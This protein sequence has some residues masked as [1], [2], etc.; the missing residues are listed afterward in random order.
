MK[1][2]PCAIR[3]QSEVVLVQSPGMAQWL[4]MSLAEQFGIAANIAFPLPAT[5][6][7]DMFVRVLPEI[8]K[9]SAFNK[10]SMSWKLMAILPAM[11]PGDEFDTAAHYLSDDDDQ[12]K[13]FQLSRAWRI[14]LTSIWFIARNGSTAGNKVR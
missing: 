4:Q 14:S 9:E 11:L 10:S 7:W 1:T 8:P 13:L 12:R 3:F 2:S 6:I 5:F